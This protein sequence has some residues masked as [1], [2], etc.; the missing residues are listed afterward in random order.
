MPLDGSPSD[1]V[2]QASLAAERPDIFLSYSRSDRAAA[3]Q[4]AEQ[5]EAKGFV[6]WWD[7]G[8][9]S[10]SDW[11][12]VL[13]TKIQRARCVMLYWSPEAEK[14]WWVGYEAMRANQL[15]K[16]LIVSFDD[17]AAK[18]QSWAKDLQAIRL[19]KPLLKKFWQT[20]DWEQLLRDL[21]H[22]LPRLPKYEFVGWLGGGVAHSGGVTAVEFNPFDE[23]S[24]LSCGKDGRAFVWSRSAARKELN[25]IQSDAGD[26]QIAVAQTPV[27]TAQFLAG[28]DQTGKVWAIQR[29]QF[30]FAG[31]AIVVA[32][33]S[34][35]ARVFHGGRFDG[36]GV[37]LPH[38]SIVYPAH[39]E[40]QRLVGQNQFVG[41]VADATIGPDGLVLTVGGGKA[42]LWNWRTSAHKDVQ[43]PSYAAGRSVNCCYS[44]AVRAFFVTDRKGRSHRVDLDGSIRPD[45]FRQRRAPGAVLGHSQSYAARPRASELCV[46][47][48]SPA[49]RTID[50]YFAKDGAYPDAPDAQARADY[51]VRALAIHP[52]SHVVG[53]A[54]GY[55]PFLV[56]WDNSQ[57]VELVGE[58][59]DHFGQVTSIAFS[60]SGQHLVVGGEDGCLSLW[61]DTL[62]RH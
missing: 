61:R 3:E 37:R 56:S 52:D 28:A 35:D 59:G 36:D 16:L 39:E 9:V 7:K 18:S 46:A 10:G 26:D 41:G 44:P 53:V 62:P 33:E 1:V 30:S 57:R 31:D 13:D 43:L 14:S 8:I 2:V 51:P 5:L 49:D 50:V 11:R 48:T 27:G 21:N 19:R 29:A 24:I 34:G 55:R 20:K 22:K 42:V 15:E 60:S 40:N 47:S 23:D 4:I 25:Q 32:S 12:E 54:S 6:V 45:V 58:G 17:V 38:L